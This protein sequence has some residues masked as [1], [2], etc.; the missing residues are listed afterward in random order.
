MVDIDLK[1]FFDEV[2]HDKLMQLLDK[3]VE[4]KSL[5]K[6]IG[7]ILRAPVQG[8]GGSRYKTGGVEN[9]RGAIPVGPSSD[10]GKSRKPPL[11]H[12]VQS[13]KEDSGSS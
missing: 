12:L 1:S 3:H 6:L 13:E 2:N 5:K 4:D 9:S 8:P 7:A 10:L 11:P